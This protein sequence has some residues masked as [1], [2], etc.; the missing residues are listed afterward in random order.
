MLVG[1]AMQFSFASG[2]KAMG[3][4]NDSR[5]FLSLIPGALFLLRVQALELG[6]ALLVYH[7]HLYLFQRKKGSWMTGSDRHGDSGYKTI[8]ELS[9]HV[10]S[11]SFS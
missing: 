2:M 8:W 5:D 9:T 6:T 4:R 1:N 11:G 10:C 3:T 7:A